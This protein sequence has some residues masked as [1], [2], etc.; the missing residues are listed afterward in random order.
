LTT[1]D[2]LALSLVEAYKWEVRKVE[3]VE[4]FECIEFF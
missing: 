3:L 1:T 2:A 4:I